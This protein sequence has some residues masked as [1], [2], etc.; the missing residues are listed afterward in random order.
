[1]VVV[2]AV[3]SRWEPSLWVL[4]WDRG[5]GE[6]RSAPMRL[7]AVPRF[8]ADTFGDRPVDIRWP[9]EIAALLD[10]IDECETRA[11]RAQEAAVAARR[12]A[13]V[14][15]HQTDAVVSLADVGAVLGVSKQRAFQ[16]LG[17]EDDSSPD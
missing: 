1:M 6:C 10:E 5:D 8:V 2:T 7:R 4:I 11:R 9:A 15:L 14:F 3:P 12:R 13:A 16:L 17:N